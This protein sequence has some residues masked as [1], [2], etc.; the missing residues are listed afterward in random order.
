ML[1]IFKLKVNT[2]EGVLINEDIFQ[3]EIKTDTGY[4]GLLANHS[5]IVG[6][7]ETS[8]CYIRDQKNERKGALVNRGIFEFNNNV[9]TI[10][11]DF[12]QYT[13]N[14]NKNVL[15]SREAA[16]NA[17]IK[18][19]TANAADPLRY[20]KIKLQLEQGIKKLRK[21]GNIEE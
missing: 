4:I 12:F 18:K 21:V 11:T 13:E 9:V 6:V 2:P 15:D 1:K 5:P 7:I 20:D 17:A 16:I 19:I 3:I 10:I 14:L 8:I